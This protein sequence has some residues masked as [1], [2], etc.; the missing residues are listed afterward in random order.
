MRCSASRTDNNHA[1]HSNPHIASLRTAAHDV[2]R[3]RPAEPSLPGA[4]PPTKRGSH[5]SKPGK[6]T[7]VE[8]MS[9]L[10]A[11]VLQAE[12]ALIAERAPQ[13]QQ[14]VQP[15]GMGRARHTR[16]DSDA[17]AITE[18]QVISETESE[19]EVHKGIQ[20]PGDTLARQSDFLRLGTQAGS[21]DPRHSESDCGLEACSKLRRDYEHL[22]RDR[23]AMQVDYQRVSGRYSK[24]K[25]EYQ[26]VNAKFKVLEAG[27][28][29][30]TAKYITA[31]GD[32]SSAK[33][34]LEE[35]RVSHELVIQQLQSAGEEQQRQ[36]RLLRAAA[37][38]SSVD[39]GSVDV[40]KELDVSVGEMEEIASELASSVCDNARRQNAR[41]PSL[42]NSASKIEPTYVPPDAI[43]DLLSVFHRA[44]VEIEAALTLLLHQILLSHTVTAIL[45]VAPAGQSYATAIHAY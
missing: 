25:V 6:A 13:S 10:D 19:T 23:D 34:T 12:M 18:P 31:K 36:I 26:G 8:P 27:H 9:Q 28:Q 40:P 5:S 17:N 42:M 11:L 1:C 33:Q 45:N 41:L 4:M 37:I 15:L 24:L 44:N 30:V 3:K 29:H 2:R 20:Q 39:S 22:Q 38:V 16:F 21:T 35:M 43:A 7:R 14:G 32:V